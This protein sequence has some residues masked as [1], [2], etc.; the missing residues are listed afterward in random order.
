MRRLILPLAALCL[1][2]GCGYHLAGRGN[3]LPPDVRTLYVGMFS[4]GTYE[5]FLEN[6]VT[7]AVTDKFVEGRQ[8]RLVEDPAQADAVLTGK[9]VAYATDPISYDRNDAI[10]EYRSRMKVRA[11]LRRR[12]GG[13]ILWQG[14]VS[15]SREYRANRL[16]MAAQQDNEAA[17]IREIG[18]RVAGELY[19]RILDSF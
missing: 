7:N 18:D 19:S 6:V 11:T 1:L 5:P 14:D 8:L 3:M 2:G 13:K 12:A 16:D 9:V 17:A 15:W 4:N 10:L